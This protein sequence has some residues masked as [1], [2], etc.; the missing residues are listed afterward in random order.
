MLDPLDDITGELAGAG[1]W[2]FFFFLVFHV[3]IVAA[4]LRERTVWFY[5]GSV[6]VL[7]EFFVVPFHFLRELLFSAATFGESQRQEDATERSS[8]I[9]VLRVAAGVQVAIVLAAVGA[10]GVTASLN[11]A[12]PS[13]IA[14]MRL[15]Q[16]YASLEAE[17]KGLDEAEE[18]QRQYLAANP[19]LPNPDPR[20][21]EAKVKQIEAEKEA[22]A[23]HAAMDANVAAARVLEEQA[24]VNYVGPVVEYVGKQKLATNE[25]VQQVK[26]S[27]QEFCTEQ[28]MAEALCAPLREVVPLRFAVL[29][30]DQTKSSADKALADVA[31]TVR[32]ERDARTATVAAN[33]E[34][35]ARY[36][37]SIQEAEAEVAAAR[38]EAGL[39]LF[40]GISTL[41]ST[42]FAFVYVAWGM[43][44]ML[45]FFLRALRWMDDVAAIRV[46]LVDRGASA[47]GSDGSLSSSPA[48]ATDAHHEA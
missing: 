11:A 34:R 42:V 25:D 43:G 40:N 45:E 28:L 27:I 16:A 22:T 47:P 24:R 10:L 1:G 9:R 46:A 21:E 15:D 4:F 31:A 2:L 13:E 38:K 41:V 6:K 5:V 26:N 48:V 23:A 12:G 3:A 33:E 17:E 37:R 35:V 19:E 36:K 7:V 29:R 30:A 14:E 44:L 18:T 8:L 32:R 39:R 20:E